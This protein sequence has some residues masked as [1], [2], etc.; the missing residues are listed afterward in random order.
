MTPKAKA[1]ELLNKYYNLFNPDYPNINVLFKDCKK[2]ALI[3]VDELIE[4]T[5]KKYWYN[6]KQEIEKL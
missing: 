2:C 4:E 6:V 5:G 3:T 1:L